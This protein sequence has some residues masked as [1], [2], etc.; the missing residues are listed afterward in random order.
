M[1]TEHWTTLAFLQILAAGTIQFDRVHGMCMAVTGTCYMDGS[2]MKQGRVNK[3]WCPQK[4]YMGKNMTHDHA[5]QCTY[6]FI[7]IYCLMPYYINCKIFLI[8]IS[9][10]MHVIL[11]TVKYGD[12]RF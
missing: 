1:S 12:S 8:Y 7:L 9:V 11:V 5:A 4:I 3:D 10:I 2:G 6:L